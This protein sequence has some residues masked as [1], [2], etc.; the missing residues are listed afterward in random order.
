MS[1]EFMYYDSWYKYEDGWILKQNH[2][3]TYNF[4]CDCVCPVPHEL[5]DMLQSFNADQLNAIMHAVL[6]S[7]GHGVVDG[8]TKKIQE[9]KRVFNLD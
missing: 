3:G 4:A 5:N 2:L 1:F 6:H 9:F 8:K 7:Y